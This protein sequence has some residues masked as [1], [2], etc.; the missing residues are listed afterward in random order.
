[1]ATLASVTA[2]QSSTAEAYRTLRTSLQFVGL[3]HPITVTQV[4]SPN[5]GDGKST[6][7]ANLG[8]QLSRAGKRVVL[9]DCDL[10]RPRLHHF[11]ALD[12][13]VGFTNVLLKEADLEDALQ[14]IEGERSLM[15]VTSGPVPPNPSEL[16]STKR[17][18]GVLRSLAEES[19]YVL[20]DSPPVLPVSDA[21]V[22][23]GIVDATILVLSAG[24]TT[25]REA[26]RAFEQ[27]DQIEAPVVGA[28]LNSVDASAHYDRAY[29]G[30][31]AYLYGTEPE[32]R[33]RRQ[34]RWPWRKRPTP[35][36]EAQPSEV[37]AS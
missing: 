32:D 8:V 9:V 16:L 17:A 22:L 10:R 25:K 21:L 23:S 12:N 7:L 3:D 30:S 11:F 31:Y 36:P 20:V 37:V 15:V 19:D 14:V 29:G 35:D 5:S 34:R 26:H 24:A 2:P 4:T 18:Q 13:T 28:V 1:V 6:T 27:L 33:P